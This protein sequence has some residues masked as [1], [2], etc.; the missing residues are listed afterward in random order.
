LA[1]GA[2]ANGLTELLMGSLGNKG[3][4]ND[5]A[6]TSKLVCFG[7]DGVSAFQGKCTGVIVQIKQNFAPHATGIHYMA[8]KIDLAVKTLS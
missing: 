4:L 2:T 6:T 3:G 7:A 5:D 8:H 1:D